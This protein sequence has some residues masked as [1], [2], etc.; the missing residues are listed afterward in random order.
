MLHKIYNK[1][2][3]YRKEQE[4]IRIKAKS[5]SFSN[6]FQPDGHISFKEFAEIIEQM[7]VNNSNNIL[8]RLSSQVIPYL[9][10]G[11]LNFYNNLFQYV[12]SGNGN[13]MSLSYTFDRS[14]LMFLSQSPLFSAEHSPTTLGLCN[15]LF[16]RMNNISR[17]IHPTHSVSVYGKDRLEITATH[18]LDPHTYST[19]SPFAY[20][21][22]HGVGKEIIIGLN[23]SSVGQHFIENV[24]NITGVIE[25]PILCKIEIDGK[26]QQK[27]FYADNPFIKN[28]STYHKDQ[29]IN[30]LKMEGILKQSFIK[31]ISVYIY[32]SRL[33]Y[34]KLGPIYNS[35][36]RPYNPLLMR[37]FFLN[38]IIRPLILKSFFE[39][40]KTHYIA[41]NINE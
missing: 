23:C 9:E 16:R 40:K 22:K 14:P 31:G 10:G 8:I 38:K 25:K 2:H 27:P 21:Y 3:T 36:K 17:S 12:D 39:E 11:I 13:L 34:D 7:G 24:T 32:D 30:F 35:D 20:L 15:E 33:F 28:F 5:T 1:Y 37:T 6:L 19:Q 41:R 29:F 4:K 18:H 26:K